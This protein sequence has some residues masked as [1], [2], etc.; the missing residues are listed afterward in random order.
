M[1]DSSAAFG[2][3]LKSRKDTKDLFLNPEKIQRPGYKSRE[4]LLFFKCCL[5]LKLRDTKSPKW[6]KS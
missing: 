1:L 6:H 5:I 4:H 2:F 3:V